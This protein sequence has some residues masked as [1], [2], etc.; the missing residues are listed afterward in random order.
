M[1]HKLDNKYSHKGIR[2]ENEISDPWNKTNGFPISLCDPL[3]Y[4]HGP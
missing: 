1:S 4:H 2:N 3:K